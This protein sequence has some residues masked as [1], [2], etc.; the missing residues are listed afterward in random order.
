MNS[1][2]ITV[3]KAFLCLPIVGFVCL[4]GTCGLLERDMDFMCTWVTESNATTH[5]LL[6]VEM[7]GEED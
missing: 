7:S 2:S 5:I 4:I 1:E 3:S 6:D